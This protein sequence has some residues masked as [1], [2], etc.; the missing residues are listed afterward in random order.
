MLNYSHVIEIRESTRRLTIYRVFDYGTK[1]LFT[2]V[3]LP[4]ASAA[5]DQSGFAR[6]TQILG[7]NLLLDSPVARKLLK[8]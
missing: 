5:E 6:F 7:E 3:E 2:D 4:Q 8:L 1:E